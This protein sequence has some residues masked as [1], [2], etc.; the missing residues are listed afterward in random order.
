M[1]GADWTREDPTAAAK[2]AGIQQV[3]AYWEALRLNGDV[4]R[5]DRIDPR[6]LAGVLESVFLIE[7]IGPGLAKFR[8]AGLYLHDLMGM[9][10]RGMP[11]STLFSSDSRLK[12]SE[13]LEVVF[14][15]PASLDLWLESPRDIA[16]PMIKA[17]MILLPLLGS[18]GA[19]NLA[20]GCLALEGQIGHAPR[21]FEISTLVTEPLRRAYPAN[22]I[23]SDHLP[24]LPRPPRGQPYLR[25]VSSRD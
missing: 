12:L 13:A 8:L 19:S 22:S 17:R 7:R 4:P 23:E 25:L 11:I 5:R 24:P 1:A 14:T 9:D 21:R 18:Q 16:R 3:R 2:F 6:G 10:V 20:L 15:A